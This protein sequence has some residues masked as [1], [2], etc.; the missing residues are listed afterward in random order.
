PDVPDGGDQLV[1]GELAVDEVAA[2]SPAQR[3]LD[4]LRL[5]AVREHHDGGDADQVR[6]GGDAVDSGHA[7]VEQ[8]DVGAVGVDG[9]AGFPAVGG[10]RH[11]GDV[12]AAGE[13]GGQAGPDHRVVVGDDD[14][15][16]GGRRRDGL[17]GAG[18]RLHGAASSAG[19]VGGPGRRG[20]GHR[21]VASRG[22]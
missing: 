15:E 1:G 12:V 11:D 10:L 21:V 18:R 8:D 13:H 2:R 17:V 9:F 22:V 7:D 16:G 14:P 3:V 4:D 6:E 19:V 20:H 5:S